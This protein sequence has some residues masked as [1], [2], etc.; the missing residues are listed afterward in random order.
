MKQVVLCDIRSHYNVGAIFRT[1]DGAGVSKIYL[2]GFTPAPEDRFGRKVP[3][4][5]KTA[6]GAEDFISWEKVEDVIG[7]I[8][9]LKSKGVKTVAVEQAENSVSLHDFKVPEKVVYI[10]GSETEGLPEE[11]LNMVDVVLELPMLGRK[12]SLNVSVTAGI[13]LY[14]V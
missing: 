3:E 11:I 5:S 4:I 10:F 12:E 14:H 13:V 2:T 8:E 7:L 6:L 9:R 1:S